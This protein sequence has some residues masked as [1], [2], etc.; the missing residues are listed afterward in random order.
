MHYQHRYHAGNFAD[1]FKH[2]LLCGLLRALN[3]KDAPWAYV[4]THAGAGAYE[5]RD[6]AQRTAAEQTGEFHDGI[7]R[8]IGA[9]A[10]PEPVAAYLDVVRAMNPRWADGELRR[11]PGSPWFAAR[12]A[13]GNDRVLLCEREAAIAAEL[14][15]TLAADPRVAIHQRDGYEAP[16]LLPPREKRGLV[17]VDPPFE[18]PDEFD[19]VGAFMQRALGRFANGVYAVWYPY[20]KRFDTE[21]FLRRL[22]RDCAREAINYM[23]ETG[24]PSEGQMH[25]CGVVVV[26]PPFAFVGEADAALPWLAQQLA[27]GAKAAARAEQWTPGKKS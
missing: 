25:A 26:N 16:A 13:R 5:L 18:R 22:R 10:A 6:A 1:V 7:A 11:Y 2:V 4:E 9:A 17:L 8:L 15:G 19:A 20:K 21:R 12:A 27:Q 24:A 3:H 14:K 23:L